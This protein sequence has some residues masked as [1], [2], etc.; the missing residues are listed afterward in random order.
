[1]HR[2]SGVPGAMAIVFCE[3][4]ARFGRDSMVDEH[5]NASTAPNF[6]PRICG[7]EHRHVRGWSRLPLKPDRR[8][9]HHLLSLNVHA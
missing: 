4:A 9:L 8:T 6:A 5:Q 7:S 2:E 1:M 3:C